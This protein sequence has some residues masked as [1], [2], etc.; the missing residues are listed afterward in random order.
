MVIELARRLV[1]R[2]CG[3]G[4]AANWYVPTHNAD[5]EEDDR[6]GVCDDHLA[7]VLA[8]GY[9]VKELTQ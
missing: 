6:L 4:T 3:P 5:G 1:C 9:T 8:C 7:S 2:W